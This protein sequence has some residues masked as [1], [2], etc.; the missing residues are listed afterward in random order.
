MISPDWTKLLIEA[1][2]VGAFVLYSIYMYRAFL[3]ALNRQNEAFDK[4]NQA[5]IEAIAELNKSI[6]GKLDRLK[7]AR[8]NS[9]TRKGS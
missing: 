3:E 9:T 7:P 5:V 1:P 4:R 8:A 6:G 2:V